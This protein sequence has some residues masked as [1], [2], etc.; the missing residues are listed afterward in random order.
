LD[1]DF[2]PVG[3]LG[4]HRILDAVLREGDAAETLGLE[5]KSDIDLSRK[6]IGIA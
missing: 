5:A 6:G 3:E 1:A 4:W 2:T